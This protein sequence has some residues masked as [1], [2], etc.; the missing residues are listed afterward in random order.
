M[1]KNISISTGGY[2][3]LSGLKKIK[4]LKKNNIFVLSYLAVNI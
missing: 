3:K 2:K 4:Y 1:D